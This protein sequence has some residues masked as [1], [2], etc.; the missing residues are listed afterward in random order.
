[1]KQYF[2]YL[3]FL[4]LTVWSAQAFAL[5]EIDRF[6][7]KCD[8]YTE[9]G[10]GA[11]SLA[12]LKKNRNEL[13]KAKVPI[14]MSF[15]DCESVKYIIEL[16]NGT[17]DTIESAFPTNSDPDV[18][19]DRFDWNSASPI[20]QFWYFTY[21]AWEDAG[22]VLIDKVDGRKIGSPQDCATATFSKQSSSFAVI[23]EGSYSNTIPSIYIFRKSGNNKIWS[24][25][26]EIKSCNEQA[27]FVSRKF[28]FIDPST[29]ILEGDCRLSAVHGRAIVSG[30]KWVKIKLLVQITEKNLKVKSNGATTKVDWD[31]VN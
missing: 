10:F 31:S 9:K 27:Y 30:K 4:L 20:P 19:G 3:S 25:P 11:D 26:I 23:C 28:E 17:K 22:W 21:G 6:A 29:L 2:R 15:A 5:D 24:E 7:K 14:Q 1:M 18:K 12:A 16:E 8:F 13:R